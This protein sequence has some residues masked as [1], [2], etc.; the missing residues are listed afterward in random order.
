MWNDLEGFTKSDNKQSSI[1]P[2]KFAWSEVAMNTCG[3]CDE[4]YTKN[5]DDLCQVCPLHVYESDRPCFDREAMTMM[6][7]AWIND[8][9]K[10]FEKYR[11]ML[12]SEMESHKDKFKI[13][14]NGECLP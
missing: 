4:F 8:D 6:K 12:I 13:T 2:R 10:E 9:P 3:F 11:K 7:K 14:Q 1:F 5:H